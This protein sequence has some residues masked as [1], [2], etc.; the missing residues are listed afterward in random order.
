MSRVEA[1][2]EK[3]REQSLDGF[4]LYN[5]ESSNRSSSWYLSGFSGSFSILV[6]TPLGEYIITDS[7]YYTQASIETPFK[8]I[9]YKNS[10][11]LQELLS[12]ILRDD[13]ALRVGFEEDTLSYGLYNRVFSGLD[14]ELRPA[15]RIMKDMRAVKS[16]EEVELISRAV[17]VAEKALIETMNFIKPGKTEEEV[18]AILEFEIRKRG[19]Y[20]AFDVIV[21]S[22]SRSAIVHGR[23]SSKKLQE[24]E[25]V[26]IDYGA[27]VEGYNSDITRTFSLGEPDEEMIRVYETV[28][29]AQKEARDVAVAGIIGSE[30]HEVAAEIIR[31]AGY[32]EYFG[33]G[34]GHSLGMDTHDSSGGAS[35]T[36][37]EPIPAG[38]V[39]TIEPGIY[40]PEKFGVRIEDDLY[41]G[42][43]GTR[44]L[45][46]LDRELKIL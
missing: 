26:L 3:L 45:T 7:R 23:P 37:K 16:P 34:L 20:M 40:L 1:F 11:G 12:S 6:I 18:S 30:L 13:G 29:R 10:N 35:P 39:I 22:G 8:L 32:G 2:R 31:N 25:F 27:R 36:N 24:G 5:F 19:G 44:V 21:G 42:S 15:D 38:A 41:L 43:E 33:H 17:S 14:V 9:P 28:Y 4:I 46:T